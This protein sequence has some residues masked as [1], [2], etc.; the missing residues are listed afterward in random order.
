METLGSPA[1][2][3]SRD[4]ASAAERLVALLDE[5]MVVGKGRCEALHSP[6][7]TLPPG[8]GALREY[9]F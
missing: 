2:H 6:V 9:V 4:C 3:G 1:P 8:I 5:P 7:S